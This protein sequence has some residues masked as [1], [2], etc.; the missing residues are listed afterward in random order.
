MPM[1]TA[2]NSQARLGEGYAER[3]AV[4]SAPK[5]I[6]EYCAEDHADNNDP[7]F[8]QVIKHGSALEFYERDSALQY[9]HDRVTRDG[10]DIN[11]KD[12]YGNTAVHYNYDHAEV[13]T[14]LLD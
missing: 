12:R 13:L 11:S 10:I 3:D 1:N 14:W 7:K 6:P 9:M 5:P 4:E 2:P 8:T